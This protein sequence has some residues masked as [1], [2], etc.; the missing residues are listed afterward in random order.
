VLFRSAKPRRAAPEGGIECGGLCR[1]ADVT[2]TTNTM[3]EGGVA[4][5]SCNAKWGA[6][7]PSDPTAGE[8]CRYFWAME[9]FDGLSRFSNTVG[10]CFK[11]AVWQYDSNLDM[12]PDAPFPRCTALTT[13][14]V[15]PP[16]MNPAENDALFFW[17]VQRPPMK[18]AAPRR[19]PQD[20]Q[21]PLRWR[22]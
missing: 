14:D 5:E 8:S 1:P 13:G 6:A 4:P 11:H 2:S 17:C 9:P 3:H 18:A 20:L 15:L 7:L 12:T 21:L 16:I 10:F 19:E 22:P